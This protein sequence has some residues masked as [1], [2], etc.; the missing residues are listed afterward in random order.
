M[1]SHSIAPDFWFLATTQALGLTA[2]FVAQ[3]T[4]GT[5]VQNFCQL[6]ALLL[7][8]VAG[9]VSVVS[10]ASGPVRCLT[11]GTVIACMVLMATFDRRGLGLR[12]CPTN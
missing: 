5:G 8:S 11:C 9:L 1:L 12:G 6:I 10:A 7:M 3:R 4:S 2:A